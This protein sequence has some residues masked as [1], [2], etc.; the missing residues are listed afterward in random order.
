MHG[1]HVTLQSVHSYKLPAAEVALL[2]SHVQVLPP[3]R[4]IGQE[5][6]VFCSPVSY[7]GVFVSKEC[8]TFFTLPFLVS[9]MHLHMHLESSGLTS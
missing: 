5:A 3:E 7:Q 6:E 9:A 4:E 2:G 1:F 8:S